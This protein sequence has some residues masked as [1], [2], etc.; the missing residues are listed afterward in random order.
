MHLLFF[1]KHTLN[2][3]YKLVLKYEKSKLMHIQTNDNLV[4]FARKIDTFI[5][6]TDFL[7]K[8]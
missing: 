8:C 6:P 7:K 2:L 5:I 4:I 3:Y 1:P